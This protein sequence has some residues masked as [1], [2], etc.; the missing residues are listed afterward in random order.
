MFSYKI[1]LSNKIFFE[2]LVSDYFDIMSNYGDNDFIF[3]NKKDD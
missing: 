2:K 3:L 1:I